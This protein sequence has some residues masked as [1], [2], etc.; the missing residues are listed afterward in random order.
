MLQVDPR[1]STPVET[2]FVHGDTLD[3]AAS[4]VGVAEYDTGTADTGSERGG[5]VRTTVTAADE[6]EFTID[7]EQ[8]ERVTGDEVQLSIPEQRK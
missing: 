3:D 2:A 4:P 1:S 8:I 6:G 7:E 5:D